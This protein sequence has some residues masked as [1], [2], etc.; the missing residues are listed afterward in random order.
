MIVDIKANWM[1]LGIVAMGTSSVAKEGDL[2]DERTEKNSA[3]R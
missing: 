1:I 3:N 2:P